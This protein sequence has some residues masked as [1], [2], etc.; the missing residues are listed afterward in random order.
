M[1]LTDPLEQFETFSEFKDIPGT[2]Q[3]GEQVKQFQSFTARILSLVVGWD[4]EA[5]GVAV[6]C[7]DETKVLYLRRLLLR[8]VVRDNGALGGILA[9]E[10]IAFSTN[11]ES[12]L[13][14]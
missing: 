2:P 13:K 1:K 3:I 4:F 11:P 10:I 7:T 6:P 9:R 12:A 5:D 14:N 8:Q